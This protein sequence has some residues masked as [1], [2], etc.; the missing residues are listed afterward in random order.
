MWV[1]DINRSNN[2]VF[3][4]S[5]ALL[6]FGN[7]ISPTDIYFAQICP[8]ENVSIFL[9]LFLFRFKKKTIPHSKSSFSCSEPFWYVWNWGRIAC[10]NI[11][12]NEEE[13]ESFTVSIYSIFYRCTIHI[14]ANNP[15]P[16]K[17]HCNQNQFC[18]CG[19]K[20][21][22]KNDEAKARFV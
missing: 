8:W 17:T 4:Q 20:E 3:E 16:L 1:S 21:R 5:K 7:L 13:K 10:C 12:M 9:V 14:T 2:L 15:K 22:K 6:L 11:F 18:L 19:A